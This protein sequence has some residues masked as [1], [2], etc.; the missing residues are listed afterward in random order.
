MFVMRRHDHVAA[1]KGNKNVCNQ[2]REKEKQPQKKLHRSTK[3]LC[4]L[5]YAYVHGL[6]MRI[7]FYQINY[8]G[9]PLKN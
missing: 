5:A 9:M 8:N 1:C 3:S 4:G 2:I 7:L 6:E